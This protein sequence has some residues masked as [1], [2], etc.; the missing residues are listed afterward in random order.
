MRC[1]KKTIEKNIDSGV[2]SGTIGMTFY[3]MKPEEIL[4]S[5][6]RCNGLRIQA[7]FAEIDNPLKKPSLRGRS[8]PG[9]TKT[10]SR[11][12]HGGYN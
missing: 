8:M 10:D 3:N 12:C 1:M 6:K 5:D 11:I 9:K 7:I 4:L 2:R